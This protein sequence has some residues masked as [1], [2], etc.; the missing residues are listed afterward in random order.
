MA[1]GQAGCNY[2]FSNNVVLGSESEIWYQDVTGTSAPIAIGAPGEFNTGVFKNNLAGATSVRFGYAFDR[3]L[4]YGK[5]GAAF[6]SIQHSS[7]NAVPGGVPLDYLTV[8]TNLSVGLLVGGGIEYALTDRVSIKGEYNYIDFGHANHSVV[9]N[10][11][12][13]TPIAQ[14]IYGTTNTN[15]E[16]EQIFK[17]G[18][19]YRLF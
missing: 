18:I 11:D 13:G 4:A 2:Q 6:A 3:L 9:V 7:S 10:S 19:N 14:T 17:V 5:V 1:G 16:H 15:N 8:G 12:P